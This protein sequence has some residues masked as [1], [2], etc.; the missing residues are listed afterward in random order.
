M[1]GGKTNLLLLHFFL[2]LVLSQPEKN[3][4]ANSTF[5]I[6]GLLSLPPTRPL[7][8][9]PVQQLGEGKISGQLHEMTDSTISLPD[10]RLLIALLSIC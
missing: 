1:E 7:W 6:L 5:A 2:H 8:C 4:E 3:T 9:L 10:M